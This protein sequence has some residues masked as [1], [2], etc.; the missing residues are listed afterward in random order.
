MV[1]VIL[2]RMER[3]AELQALLPQHDAPPEDSAAATAATTSATTAAGAEG[4]A[5]DGDYTGPPGKYGFCVVCHKRADHYCS[6]TKDPVCGRECKAA[7]LE[8]VE[9]ER[10]QQQQPENADRSEVAGM[11]GNRDEVLRKDVETVFALLCHLSKPNEEEV[12]PADYSLATEVRGRILALELLLSVLSNPGPVFRSHDVYVGLV[13]KDLC[14]N[15]SKNGVSPNVSLFELSLSIFLTLVSHFK[16]PLKN[17]IQVLFKDIFLKV[18]QVP[19]ST[20][21]QKLMVLQGLA[22]ICSNPQTLVDFYLNY[23]CGVVSDDVFESMVNEV[24]KVTKNRVRPEGQE[25]QANKIRLKGLRCLVAVINSF[26]EW[27][28]EVPAERAQHQHPRDAITPVPVQQQQTVAAASDS[29]PAPAMAPPHEG[30]EAS[31]LSPTVPEATAVVDNPDQFE[32]MKNRKMALRQG[33]EKFNEKPLKGLAFVVEAG[34][35]ENTPEALA[36]FL[37]S[38][39]G[40]D[41]QAIGTVLGDEKQA[42][43]KILHAFVD[44]LDFSGLTFTTALRRFLQTFRL[45]GEAQKI[46]RIVEKYSDRFCDNN[47]DV[48]ANADAAYTLAF[49]VIMLNTDLH[50]PQIKVKMTKPQFIKNNRGINNGG[51]LDPAYLEEI[52]DDILGDEIVLME[53]Q[54]AEL[55]KAAAGGQLTQKQKAE[56]FKM[57]MEQ[58]TRKLLAGQADSFGGYHSGA[59]GEHV[60]PMFMLTW[61]AMLEALTACYE[62]FTEDEYVQASLDGF[63]GAARFCCLF[64]LVAEREVL[65]ERLAKFAFVS[66]VADMAQKD[67][68]AI[69]TLLNVAYENA[70]AMHDSWVHVLQCVSRLESLHLIGSGTLIEL[71]NS[72][73]HDPKRSNQIASLLNLVQQFQ[74]QATAIAIDKIFSSSGSLDGQSIAAFIKSLCT[75]SLEEVNATDEQPRMFSMQKIVEIAYYNMGR[76]RYEWTLIWQVLL[77]YFNQIGCHSNT[78]V[79]T[80]AVDALRQLSMKFLEK[81]ELAHFHGQA[82]SM[83]PFEY[84]VKHNRS[85][86]IRDYALK[87][88]EQMIRARAQNIKSGWKSI[89]V[90]VSRAAQEASP[91]LVKSAFAIVQLVLTDYFEHV[92]GCFVDFVSCIVEFAFTRVNEELALSSIVLLQ[93]CAK[94]VQDSPLEPPGISVD[95]FF[96][97]WFP[98][99]SGLSRVVIDCETL[100]VRRKALDTAFGLLQLNGAKFDPT[101]WRT[102]FRS[103]LHPIFEDLKDPEAKKHEIPSV[104]WVQAL[105]SLVEIYSIFPA[106]LSGHGMLDSTLE[107]IMTFVT[108]KNDSLAKTGAGCIHQIISSNAKGFTQKDWEAVCATVERA[109]EVTAPRDLVIDKATKR[110]PPATVKS[111]VLVHLELL[112]ALKDVTLSSDDDSIRAIP[113]SAKSLFLRCFFDSFTFAQQFNE[114]HDLRLALVHSGFVEKMPNL[115]QQET[116]SIQAY[117]QFAFRLYRLIPEAE[118]ASEVL[119]VEKCTLVL[120]GFRDYVGDQKKHEKE[121]ALWSPIV[122]ILYQELLNLDWDGRIGR[123]L[124]IL[125]RLTASLMMIESPTVRQELQ[126]FMEKVGVKFF[127]E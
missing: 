52:Y 12:L 26:L 112:R 3:S 53:E 103:V 106:V 101:F 120:A 21:Q 2:Q 36:T 88:L 9:R 125:F 62:D 42:N 47:P 46:D 56:L 92:A 127:A 4:A 102:V 65:V 78:K 54:T 95:D 30:G 60:R 16:A 73:P 98:I 27:L 87:S 105:K 25:A 41:K 85:F 22:K 23:D 97:R 59:R 49:S 79:A 70:N 122:V 90:V 80:F 110:P 94:L 96:L 39:P 117:L 43:I 48:F 13:R 20:Y 123:H 77:P 75:V 115:N 6:Q 67:L 108:Q 107:Y 45:P 31:L 50:S 119:L 74:S 113:G 72:D 17:E 19:T 8:R 109:F 1:G 93:R 86:T 34:L 71:Q 76:I 57:E 55:A 91:E 66:A 44:T 10:Q 28:K 51:D 18:L 61:K 29:A 89:F 69:H 14:L 83:R 111:A 82:E 63:Q 40:L 114:D 5:T 37:R 126:A 24:V 15:L 64:T 81:D 35:V 99:L 7:N 32:E 104:I 11:A 118:F 100:S 58:L 33:I 124:P 84:I 121:L 38:T 68:S 116:V